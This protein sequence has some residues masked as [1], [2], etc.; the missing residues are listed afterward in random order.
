MKLQ[1]CGVSDVGRVRDHNED[2]YLENHRLGLFVVADGM[3]G[4]NAGEVASQLAVDVIS[5]EIHAH[6]KLAT[7]Y[8]YGP[9]PH[10]KRQMLNMLEEAVQKACR[11]IYEASVADEEKRGMGTTLSALNLVGRSAFLAHVGDSRIYLI[12]D[13]QIHLLTHDHTLI[14]EQLRK[15]LI[16]EEEV[17]NLAQYRNVITR[18][19]GLL[20]SVEVDTLHVELA[21]GDRFFMCSDGLHDPIKDE[22]IL[23][24][25]TQHSLEE[26]THRLIALANERGGRDNI[27]ALAVAI[28][29]LP[30]AEDDIEVNKKLET[31]RQIP[32]FERLSYSE[33]V[34]ALNLAQLQQRRKG[35]IIIRQGDVGD[36]LFII[37]RGTVDILRDDVY[38]TSLERGGHFGE[39]SLID[40]DVRSAT[41]RASSDCDLLTIERHD[42]YHLLQEEPQLS[43][44]ILMAFVGV[45]SGR[46]RDTTRAFSDWRRHMNELNIST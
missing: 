5:A 2:S 14:N 34:K 8:A 6:Q 10:L 43:V 36:K 20:K 1:S 35:D 19:V 32:F 26:L 40:N 23:D 38:L 22:E 21:P 17:P 33:L 16:T 28:P 7:T 15:G 25:F 9:T 42:F 3:G 11:R 30:M 39:M 41:V 37:I 4:H 31:L 46:L 29:D 18:G 24:M 13:K 12:R 44:K 45:L 27:T